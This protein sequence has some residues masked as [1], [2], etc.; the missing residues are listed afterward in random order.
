MRVLAD[1]DFRKEKIK[2]GVAFEIMQV[3]DWG[4]QWNRATRIRFGKKQNQGP[5]KYVGVGVGGLS[6]NLASTT[7]MAASTIVVSPAPVSE[8]VGDNPFPPPLAPSHLNPG[9]WRIASL[10]CPSSTRVRKVVMGLP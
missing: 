8:L 10:R 2:Q 7:S 1:S 5:C 9:T 4:I 3:V 6:P